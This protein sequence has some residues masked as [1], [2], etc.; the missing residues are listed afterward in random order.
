MTLPMRMLREPGTA[1]IVSVR[2]RP[3]T[4]SASSSASG[5]VKCHTASDRSGQ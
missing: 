3:L 5:R 2:V 4:R 1:S